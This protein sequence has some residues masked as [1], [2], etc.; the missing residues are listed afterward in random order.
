[1]DRLGVAR[2]GGEWRGTSGGG[3]PTATDCGGYSVDWNMNTMFSNGKK[4]LVF[5]FKFDH[6]QHSNAEDIISHIRSY[7][8]HSLNGVRL[9]TCQSESWR[10]FF[11]H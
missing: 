3:Q 6:H 5:F 8:K 1:M 10:V 7:E 9:C 2:N 11:V 4:A